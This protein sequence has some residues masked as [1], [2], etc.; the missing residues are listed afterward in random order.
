[1]AFFCACN[2]VPPLIVRFPPLATTALEASASVPLLLIVPPPFI[3][4]V[5]PVVPICLF[6]VI[7]FPLVLSV[8][9]LSVL[10]VVLSVSEF[11]TVIVPPPVSPPPDVAPVN[12]WFKV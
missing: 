4:N 5:P 1:M 7:V 10:A 9:V 2:L 12:A 8:I 11:K 6:L 3:V